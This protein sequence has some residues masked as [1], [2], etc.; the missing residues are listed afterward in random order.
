MNSPVAP[1]PTLVHTSSVVDPEPAL[2]VA[3]A[4]ARVGLTAATLRTWHRRYGL[5]PSVRTSGGHRRYNAR[6]L[7]RLRVVQQ[8]VDGGVPP[9]EA[10][11][12]C[13]ELAPDALADPP[14]I[15]AGGHPGGG[16]V[17]PL[18]DGDEAQRGL[19]RAAVSLDAVAISRTV[20][21]LLDTYGVVAAWEQVIAP[22]MVALGERWYRTK[23]GIEIEHITSEAVASA[24]RSHGTPV[25]SD[26]RPVLLACVPDELH[27]LPLVA[28]EAAL[29]EAG[30]PVVGLGSRVPVEAVAD[31]VTRLRPRRIVWWAQQSALADPLVVDAV[32]RQ[33]PPIGIVLA[34]PGWAGQDVERAERPDSLAA[35]VSLLTA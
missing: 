22:V 5:G 32:P 15:A 34:G 2:S 3:E 20:T 23:R 27:S 26:R 28:L 4:A 19:A 21:E 25:T 16:R 18:P 12:A 17:L 24:L 30:V 13:L 7:A 10:V 9:G 14:T 35:A 6:D 33:R 31:A 1:D 8:M 11:A 29:R